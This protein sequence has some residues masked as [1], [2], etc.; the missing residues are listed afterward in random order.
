MCVCSHCLNYF[1]N[2]LSFTFRYR[3]SKILTNL[4]PLMQFAYNIYIMNVTFAENNLNIINVCY[5]K[6][7]S[8]CTCTRDSST[9]RVETDNRS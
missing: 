3:L 7:I 2:Y 9:R 8:M 5:N 4:H 1:Q 6:S